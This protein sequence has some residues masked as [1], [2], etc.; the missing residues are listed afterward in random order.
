MPSSY[1][2]S[3]TKSVDLTSLKPFKIDVTIHFQ[4]SVFKERISNIVKDRGYALVFFV[5]NEHLMLKIAKKLFKKKGQLSVWVE[6]GNS[7]EI[8]TDCFDPDSMVYSFKDKETQEDSMLKVENAL[9]EI[10]DKEFCEYR[11]L[12]QTI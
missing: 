5:Y 8:L 10:L 9:K 4:D 12:M 11:K 7:N 6:P 1:T 3:V 2:I